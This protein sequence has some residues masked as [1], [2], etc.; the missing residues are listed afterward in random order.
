MDNCTAC[1]NQVHNSFLSN[2]PFLAQYLLQKFCI[3]WHLND[4]LCKGDIDLYFL[5]DVQE[6]RKLFFS[7][8]FLKPLRKWKCRC[9][10]LCFFLIFLLTASLRLFSLCLFPCFCN[11]LWHVLFFLHF[12]FL[13][14][15]LQSLPS[16]LFCC[17]FPLLSHFSTELP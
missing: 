9:V 5:E 4:C 14:V 10:S 6:F 1:G 12:Q 13:L 17:C 11:F 8:C 15:L 7:P 16:F 3:I 2:L